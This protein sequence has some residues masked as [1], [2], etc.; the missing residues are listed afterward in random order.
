[1]IPN[2]IDKNNLI[3]YYFKVFYRLIKLCCFNLGLNDATFV[4]KV[5]EPCHQVPEAMVHRH[6]P[7]FTS[8]SHPSVQNL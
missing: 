2:I 3:I 5:R 4:L 6:F 8:I 7:W 1:M